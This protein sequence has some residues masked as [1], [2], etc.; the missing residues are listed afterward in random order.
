[1]ILT[2]AQLQRIMPASTRASLFLE[3]LN[4]AMREFG[5]DSVQRQSMFLA[6]VGA[7]SGQLSALV[8]NLNY[9]AERIRQIGNASPAG[10]RWRSLVSRAAELARNPEHM[11]NAVYCNRMG[12]GD[13]ASGEGFLYRGRGLLQTTGKTNYIALMMALGIDCAVHPELLEQPDGSARAA[14]FFW[15]ANDL[16]EYADAGDF[17]GV[18]DIINIGRKSAAVGDSVDYATRLVLYKNAKQVLS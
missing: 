2:L 16:S 7:E 17:D 8:E 14:A 18:C 4:A 13:E 3:P 15:H 9:S 6:N 10:S 12:N 5:I 1:M 11:G